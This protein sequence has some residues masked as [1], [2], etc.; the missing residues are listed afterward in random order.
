MKAILLVAV[1]LLLVSA[2]GG[3]LIDR[4]SCSD[5]DVEHTIGDGTYVPAPWRQ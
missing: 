5:P 3:V 2:A 4:F 1:L